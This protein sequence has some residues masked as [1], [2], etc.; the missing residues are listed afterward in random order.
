MQI[1]ILFVFGSLLFLGLV[2]SIIPVLPGPLLSYIALL[3]S[4][5]FINELNVDSL[6]WI[7]IAV[8][9]ISFTDYFLMIYG[10]KKAGGSKLSIWGSA[11]GALLG[12]LL[13]PPIAIFLGSFIGAYIGAKFE[14]Q[15][16]SIMISF[17]ALWGFMAGVIL[18]FSISVYIIYFLLF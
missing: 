10:V 4:H 12:L 2:G 18:K 9:V 1:L 16:D 11:L 5:L 13:F 6:T 8:V 7:G 15:S 17:G 14:T 3:L